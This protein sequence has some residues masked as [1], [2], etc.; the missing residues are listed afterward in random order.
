MGGRKIEVLDFD[1]RVAHALESRVG[2]PGSKS[3]SRIARRERVPARRRVRH[4]WALRWVMRT[5]SAS[6]SRRASDPEAEFRTTSTAVAA[7]QR[8]PELC[9]SI[10][11]TRG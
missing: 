11:N 1:L 10:A 6:P 4:R 9:S 2:W 7:S 3:A 8:I 5:R